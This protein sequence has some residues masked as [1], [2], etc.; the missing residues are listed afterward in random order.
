MKRSLRDA[1]PR[2]RRAERWQGQPV[3]R[4]TE[5]IG[6]YR[7]HAAELGP[8]DAPCMVLI[9][10]L[11]GS[12]GWWRR[13]AP[14]FAERYRVVIPDVIGFGRTRCPGVLPSIEELARHLGRWFELRRIEAPVV[15]GHS[16]GGEIAIHLAAQGSQVVDRLVLV[17]AAGVPRPLAPGRLA[18]YAVGLLPPRRWGDPRFLPV[19]VNDAWTAGPRVVLRAV[20][21]IMRDDVRPLLP[22]VQVPTLIVWGEHDTVV[23]MAD[24]HLLHAGITDSRLVVIPEAA[25]NPMIDRPAEFAGVVLDFLAAARTAGSAGDTVQPFGHGPGE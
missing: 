24:A 3:R 22:A 9:H 4:H 15:V 10:G 20:G 8:E 5:R 1:V 18:R 21:Q 12:S 11:C 19:I 23:P 14:R 2:P 25:H 17:D 16:M 6:H 13:V 7:I